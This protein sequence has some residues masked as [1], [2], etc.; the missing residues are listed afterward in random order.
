[1]ASF[2]LHLERRNG[3]LTSH[4]TEKGEIWGLW[5]DFRLKVCFS[6]LNDC[7]LCPGAAL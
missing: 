6:L 7:H 4:Y 1:M 2:Q 5:S 3:G